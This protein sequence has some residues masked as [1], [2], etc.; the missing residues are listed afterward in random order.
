MLL[1]GILVVTD[2]PLGT[3]LVAAVVAAGA[4]TFGMP[5]FGRLVPAVAADAEQLGRANVSGAAS[6]VLPA[7]SA[8][9]WPRS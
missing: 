1:M 6:T 5:A 2:A 4:G 7:S 9:E 8:P 3:I